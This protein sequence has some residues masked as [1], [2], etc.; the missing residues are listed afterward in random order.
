MK[1]D[2]TNA[3]KLVM[4]CI[5][6]AGKDLVLS[7]VVSTVNDRYDKTWAPQTVSTYMAQLVKKEFLSMTRNGKVY[8]YHPLVE[9]K[10]YFE[11]SLDEFIKFWGF[12]SRE[13]FIKGIS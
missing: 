12:E 7:E 6:D 3:E 5:W 11:K 1:K 2:L 13:D 8:T 4:K 10:D 9:Q